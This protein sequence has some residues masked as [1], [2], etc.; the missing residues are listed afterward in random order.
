[1]FRRVPAGLSMC[2][3]PGEVLRLSELDISRVQI[4]SA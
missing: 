4:W 3:Q 2:R 1:V